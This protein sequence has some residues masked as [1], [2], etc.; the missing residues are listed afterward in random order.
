MVWST[1]GIHNL[2]ALPAGMPYDAEFFCASVL[3]HIERNLCD[4]K[5]GKTLR[6]VYLHLDNAPAHNRKRSRQEIARTKAT[7][8]VHP[9]YSR[10]AVPSDFFLFGFMKG[11][12]AGFTAKPPADILYEIH[13][14]F[15]EISKE[16]LMPVYGKWIT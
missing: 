10:D 5:H 11:E 4:G 9:V 15:Q 14:I 12:M 6:G 2:L 1:F 3:P 16:T 8:A 7:E 13:R